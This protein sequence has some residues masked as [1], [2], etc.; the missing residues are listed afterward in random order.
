[1]DMGGPHGGENG[2]EHTTSGT[3][4]P[5]R[6]GRE[7][8]ARRGWDFVAVH[9]QALQQRTD[10]HVV[11]PGEQPEPRRDQRVEQP[12]L[13]LPPRPVQQ[14]DHPAAQPLRRVDRRWRLAGAPRPRGGLVVDRGVDAT[15]LQ[16]RDRDAR[17]VAGLL[18]QHADEP[19]LAPLGGDVAA[20]QR[21]RDLAEQ[22]VDDDEASLPLLPEH[23]QHDPREGGG[24]VHRRLD[25]GLEHLARDVLDPSVGHHLRGMDDGVEPPEPPH[26]VLDRGAQRVLVGDVGGVHEHL[27]GAVGPGL[28]GG[29]VQRLRAPG[30]EHEPDAA[31]GQL[32]GGR[33]ANATGGTGDQHDLGAGRRRLRG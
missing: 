28:V 5:L 19:E 12:G 3:R 16:D 15:G 26:G 24:A 13:H 17:D 23:R 4:V 20:H 2:E 14:R 25:D 21:H 22:R 27:R 9:G 10:E 1:M 33:A 29:V 30:D 6:A 11:H 18:L 31:G 32:Q 7:D 8:V